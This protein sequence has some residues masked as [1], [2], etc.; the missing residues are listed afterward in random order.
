MQKNNLNNLFLPII[1]FSILFN[2]CN[3]SAVVY[4]VK[5]YG[6]IGDGKT[7]D[8]NAINTAI[9]ACSEAGGGTVLFP[10]DG[11]YLTGSIH[12]KSNI[13]YYIEKGATIIRLWEDDLTMLRVEHIHQLGA[14]V[15]VNPGHPPTQ[16]EKS[17]SGDTTE[18][19][20]KKFQ[21]LG[22]DMVFVN[23]IEMARGFVK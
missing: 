14:K 2:S 21:D 3:N 7:F 16:E 22:V 6:A 1:F 8:T 4:N 19:E 10:S 18:E 20:L 5:E 11:T 12:L 9:S 23:D 15:L 13:I 17:T